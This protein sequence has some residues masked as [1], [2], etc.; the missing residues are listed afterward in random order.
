MSALTWKSALSQL[1]V[2][3]SVKSVSVDGGY[4]YIAAESKFVIAD[5]SK[6]ASPVIVSTLAH[7]GS[8]VLIKGTYAYLLSGGSGVTVIDISSKVAPRIVTTDQTRRSKF[9]LARH[10]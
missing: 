7:G 6:P 2:G 4:L 1:P 5:V 3:S 8:D 10:H 9:A